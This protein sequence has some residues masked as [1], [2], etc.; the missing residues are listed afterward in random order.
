[1]ARVANGLVARLSD[2]DEEGIFLL[3]KVGFVTLL[4]Q[5]KGVLLGLS[6]LGEGKFSVEVV[7]VLT[8][9]VSRLRFSIVAMPGFL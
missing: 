2:F 1:V 5:F 6:E 9:T 7:M 4:A 8:E 3:G